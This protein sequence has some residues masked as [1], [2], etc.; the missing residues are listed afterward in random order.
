MHERKKAGTNGRR[1]WLEETEPTD[2]SDIIILPPAITRVVLRFK[3]SCT[4]LAARVG[5]WALLL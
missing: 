4:V 1:Q 2:T 3:T 5:G